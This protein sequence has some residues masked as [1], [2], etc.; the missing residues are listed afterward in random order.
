MSK[1]IHWS[2]GLLLITFGCSNLIRLY[3]QGSNEGNPVIFAIF[4]IVCIIMGVL[5][6]G[7]ND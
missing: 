3:V 4:L 5:L 1:F 7:K 6:V 2:I